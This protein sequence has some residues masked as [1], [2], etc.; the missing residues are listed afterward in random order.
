M[1]DLTI[2]TARIFEFLC[3]PGF[4]FGTSRPKN[5]GAPFVG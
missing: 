3:E 5:A 1:T 4:F 2:D